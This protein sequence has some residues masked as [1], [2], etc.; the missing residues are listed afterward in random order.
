M[1]L[2]IQIQTLVCIKIV[3]ENEKFKE[4][5]ITLEH[6]NTQRIKLPPHHTK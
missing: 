5:H 3:G 6:K 4:I 2:K 1:M